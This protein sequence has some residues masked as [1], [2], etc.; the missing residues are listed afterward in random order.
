MKKEKCII[1]NIPA[2]IWGK[3]SKKVYIFIHGKNGNKEV[4]VDFARIAVNHGYQTLSIDLPEHGERENE[5]NSFDPWH[6]IPELKTL[7]NWVKDNW[8]NI[9]LRADSIGAWFSML[10]FAN[11]NF[12]NCLFVSPI[13]DM[14]ILIRNMMRWSFVSEDKLRQELEISTDFG[15]VLSWQYLDFAKKNPIKKWNFPTAILYAGKDNLTERSVVDEFVGKFL[16]QLTIFP[17]GEHWFHTL[18]Q[19]EILNKWTEINICNL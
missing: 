14:E 6:I 18:E 7:L 2:I 15:E 16:C 13:L 9:N 11:D 3:S 17:D 4:A 19:L 5:K 1:N 12:E 8:T 10:S